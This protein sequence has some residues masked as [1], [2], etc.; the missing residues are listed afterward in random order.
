LISN[1]F[2]FTTPVL[3]V[4]GGNTCAGGNGKDVGNALPAVRQ[5]GISQAAAIFRQAGPEPGYQ[6][7]MWRGQVGAW[8]KKPVGLSFEGGL[9]FLRGI[10]LPYPVGKEYMVFLRS[11]GPLLP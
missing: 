7:H 9:H 5:A 3:I 11:A 10:P 4:E 6:V 2:S 1:I 8:H